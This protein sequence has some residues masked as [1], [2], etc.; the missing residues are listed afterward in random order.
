MN[1]TF[2]LFLLFSSVAKGT[3][4]SISPDG[5]YNDIVI[6][7]KKSVPEDSCRQILGGIKVSFLLGSKRRT[8]FDAE[9]LKLTS[10]CSKW[11][12]LVLIQFL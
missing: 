7:I 1:F 3:R 12:A 8:E 9:H 11:S 4:I 10:R 2:L 5:G 6:K